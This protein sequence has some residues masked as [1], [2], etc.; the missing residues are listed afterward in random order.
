MNIKNF[1]AT[2]MLSLVAACGGGGG[3]SGGGGSE[4][5]PPSGKVSISA[6]APTTPLGSG[7]SV[8]FDVTI[9]NTT[10]VAASNVVSSL[11]L[12]SGLAL[13]GVTCAA[14]SG[15]TC[16]ADAATMSVASLPANGTLHYIVTATI[17]AS[18]RG[19]LTANAS[20]TVNGFPVSPDDQVALSVQ[21]F[22]ADVQVTA[23]AATATQTSGGVATYTRPCPTPARTR[24]PTSCWRTTSTRTRRWV[25]S[26]ATRRAAPPAPRRWAA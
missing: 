14:T 4:P 8:Q 15:A 24:P 19:K 23:L 25:S 3:S 5:P 17:G 20:M 21:V 11:T 16:P 2:A 12:G 7:G 13:T 6:A 26:P 22:M 1:L 9:R 18:M 10:A